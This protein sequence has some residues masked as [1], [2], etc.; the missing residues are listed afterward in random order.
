MA[1]VGVRTLP[2]AMRPPST[3]V[4]GGTMTSASFGGPHP[5]NT[6]P[7]GLVY[8]PATGAWHQPSAG[9]PAPGAPGA[10]PPPNISPEYLAQLFPGGMPTS[11]VNTDPSQEITGILNN[12]LPLFGQQQHGLSDAL[13]NAGI[14][15]GS[16]AGA[17]GDLSRAQTSQATA[18]VAP[19]MQVAQQMG[20]NQSEFNTGNALR[21]G[22]FDAS[23]FNQMLSQMLGFQNTDWLAQLQGQYGMASGAAGSQAGAYQPVFSQPSSPNYMQLGSAFAPGAPAAA[24]P[25]PAPAAAGGLWA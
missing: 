20:L 4:P 3:G 1:G 25:P 13:A 17:F 23:T 9:A 21:S 5:T 6:P 24:P 8:N 14:V 22:E 15:G 2:I 11:N 10:A 19:L 16:T 12:L 7:P 18:D